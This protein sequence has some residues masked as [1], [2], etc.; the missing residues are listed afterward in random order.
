MD[1]FFHVSL[2]CVYISV[3]LSACKLQC[4]TKK[5]KTNG[6]NQP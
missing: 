1:L 4:A 3:C 6:I 5:N 2:V